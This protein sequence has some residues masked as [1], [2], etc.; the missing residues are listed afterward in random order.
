MRKC[1][2]CGKEIKYNYCYKI[3]TDGKTYCL[4]CNPSVKGK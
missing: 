4:G 1:S 3:E 2:K